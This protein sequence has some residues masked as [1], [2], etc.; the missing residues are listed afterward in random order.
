M[1]P[2]VSMSEDELKAMQERVAQEQAYRRQQEAMK[3]KVAWQMWEAVDA[4][5][6]TESEIIALASNFRHYLETHEKP[7]KGR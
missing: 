1:R 7:M 4:G 3:F 6:M 5:L 2:Y